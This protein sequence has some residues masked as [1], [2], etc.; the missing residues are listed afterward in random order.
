MTTDTRVGHLVLRLELLLRSELPASYLAA[1]MCRTETNCLGGDWIRATS[2]RRATYFRSIW[3][4]DERWKH[5]NNHCVS[6]QRK[7]VF[8]S[9]HPTTIPA[10]ADRTGHTSDVRPNCELADV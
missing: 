7:N 2:A 1:V 8:S 5:R 9:A 6:R 4:A 10:E 3:V